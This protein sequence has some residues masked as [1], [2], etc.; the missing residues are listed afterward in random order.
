MHRLALFYIGSAHG[1]PLRKVGYAWSKSITGPWQRLDRPL[2]LGE[3]HNN[4]APYVH[5][6]GRVLLAFRNRELHMHIASA[7]AWNG[8]YRIV[9]GISGR[10]P[11]WKIRTWRSERVGTR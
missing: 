4:P 1:S 5:E 9:A 6:D 8:E 7:D 11:G 3:D 10:T 2:P